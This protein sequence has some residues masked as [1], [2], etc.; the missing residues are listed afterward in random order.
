MKNITF[1]KVYKVL[2]LIILGYALYLLKTISDTY[3]SKQ[4]GRFVPTIYNGDDSYILDTQ[5]G[6]TY[7]LNEGS[8]YWKEISKGIEESLK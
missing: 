7:I 5:T 3:S 1:D 2:I 6:K 8:E 4:N